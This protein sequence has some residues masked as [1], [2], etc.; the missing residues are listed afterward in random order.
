MVKVKEDLSGKKFGR[1][2][3]INQAEDYI[4][5]KSGTHYAQW[6]CLCDCGNTKIV[7][8]SKLK[9]GWTQSCGCL[10]REVS[11]DLFKKYNTYD[12]ESKE[13]GIGYTSKGEEFWFDKEDYDKIKHYCWW[14]D[15]NS[16]YLL[17]YDDNSKSRIL[18]HR[19]VMN[20]LNSPNILIDHKQH[21]KKPNN[22]YDNRKSNLRI[23]TSTNNR[24]NQHIRSDNTSGVTGVSWSKRDNCWVAYI[25]INKKRIE[26][27][28]SKDK[29]ECIKARKDAEE[30]YFGE[31]SF[32]NSQKAA[33]E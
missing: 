19:L 15:H 12:L 26:L 8:G 25:M 14:Y 9:S 23:G 24:M 32:D 6:N 1:L 11:K 18:L 28:Y 4:A 27:K 7:K 13:Y 29:N 16:G 17:A 22:I 30:K 3:V 33:N 20:V 10:H 21:P 2:F 5:P 31:W